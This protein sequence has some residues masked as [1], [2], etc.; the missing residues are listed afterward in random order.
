MSK[1]FPRV[2]SAALLL[3]ICLGCSERRS[4]APLSEQ[5]PAANPAAN[6]A[7]EENPEP[8]VSLSSDA[9]SSDATATDQPETAE[10]A[11]AAEN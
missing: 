3:T 5:T 11:A 8:D 1:N 7:A 9:A 2:A 4:V 10:P 6:P